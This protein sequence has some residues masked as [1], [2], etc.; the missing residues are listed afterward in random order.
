MSDLKHSRELQEKFELYLLALIFTILGLAIQTAKLGA[1]RVVDVL[2]V[3]GWLSLVVSGL[4]GLSRLEWVPVAPK[5]GSQLQD[6]RNERQQ[7]A[8]TAEG[9]LRRVPVVDQLEPADIHELIAMRDDTIGRTKYRLDM[10]EKATLQL[11]AR[12]AAGA[13]HSHR[14]VRHIPN[15]P[16]VPSRLS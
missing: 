14:Q 16:L 15:R 4:I 11:R 9:G 1:N 10:I 6:I 2:E 8:D 7:R 5:S 13:E 12:V 3:L